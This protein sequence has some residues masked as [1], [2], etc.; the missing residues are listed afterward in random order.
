VLKDGAKMSKSK[1]N[2]VDPQ[3][4]IDQYGADTVR[5]FSMFAAPP[6][7][8]LEWSDEGVEGAARYL[9]RLWFQVSSFNEAVAGNSFVM[10]GELNKAQQALRLKIHQTIDKVTQDIGDRQTFNTAIAAMMELTNA[11]TKFNDDSDN[12]MAIRHEG[13]LN[14]V[15]MI[16]PF[17][18]HMAQALWEDMGE[19]ELL[20]DAP[21]PL[22]DPSALVQDE[23]ELVVQVNGKLRAKITVAADADKALAEALALADENVMKFVSGKTIRKV[24]VVPGRLIN[25]VVS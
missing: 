22:L 12:G 10:S 24:I 13:W 1:G 23:I 8:S 7:Q 25:V 11:M 6:E 17:A 3:D 15:K 16:S 14:L 21:W 4:L 19:S 2:T 18:P 9:N 5:L 20:C